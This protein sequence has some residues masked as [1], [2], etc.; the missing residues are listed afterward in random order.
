MEPGPRRILLVDDEPEIRAI[1][2]M[3]LEMVATSRSATSARPRKR[4]RR[5]RSCAPT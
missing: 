2:R 1:A 3:A 5:R 4:S